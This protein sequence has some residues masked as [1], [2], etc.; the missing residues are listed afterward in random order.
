MSILEGLLLGLGSILFI[1]PVFFVILQ[2]TLTYGKLAGLYI[3]IG[4][5]IS[6]L[7]YMVFYKFII[8][9]SIEQYIDSPIF[10]W[11]FAVI[12]TIM[13]IVNILKKAN[14][15]PKVKTFKNN[16]LILVSKGFLINFVNPFVLVFWL[17]VFKYI[18]HKF[19]DTNQ[20]LFLLSALIGIFII[21]IVKVLFSSYL[22]KFLNP[23]TLQITHKFIGVI[24][25]FF[26]VYMILHKL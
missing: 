9:D 12:L 21:D 2:N 4:I 1:G 10:Y 22:K 24:F 5:L 14:E 15:S 26:S 16:P 23:K 3:S 13:G 18:N 11:I 25:L 19:D 7:I 20:Y 6:D 8:F 17:G